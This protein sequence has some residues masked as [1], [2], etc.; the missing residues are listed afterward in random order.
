MVVTSIEGDRS[1][2]ELED[3]VPGGANFLESDLVLTLGEIILR[4]SEDHEAVVRVGEAALILGRR[5]LI[6]GGLLIAVP[7][8]VLAGLT[9]HALEKLAVLE[10]VIDGVAM[11]GARLFQELFEVVGIALSLARVVD[12]RDRVVVCMTSVLLPFPLP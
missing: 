10:L 2:E 6:F 3:G 7:T 4:T 12:R 11:T 5:S 9:Q 1:P 8:L